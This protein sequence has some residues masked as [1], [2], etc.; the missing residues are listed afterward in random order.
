VKDGVEHV[1]V[2]KQNIFFYQCQ[3][4]KTCEA[5]KVH[6]LPQNLPMGSFEKK[7]IN[8]ASMWKPMAHSLSSTLGPS[9]LDE[10]ES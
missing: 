3:I 7:N 5:I 1:G 4:E 2:T 8:V 9:I 6:D 10:L